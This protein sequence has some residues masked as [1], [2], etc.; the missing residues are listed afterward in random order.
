[1]AASS[2]GVAPH[3]RTTAMAA[4]SMGQMFWMPRLPAVMPTVAPAWMRGARRH[5]WAVIA[6]TGSSTLGRVKL[7]RTRAMG[8]KGLR[9][10]LIFA[11]SPCQY[12]PIMGNQATA[13]SAQ[14]AQ[15]NRPTAKAALSWSLTV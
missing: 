1:M 9:V 15:A 5:I 13:V 3:S 4:A 11:L 6:A 8:G 7:W 2:T 14:A 12:R 10:V